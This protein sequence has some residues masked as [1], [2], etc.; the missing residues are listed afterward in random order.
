VGLVVVAFEAVGLVV[1]AFEA[2]G[3]CICMDDGEV[4]LFCCSVGV[5]WYKMV[6]HSELFDG[7]VR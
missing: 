5:V 1:V 3:C 4:R 6:S 2:A 7:I